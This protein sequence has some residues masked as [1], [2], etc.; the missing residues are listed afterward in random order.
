MSSRFHHS[1]LEIYNAEIAAASIGMWKCWEFA[2]VL[3]LVARK[4]SKSSSGVGRVCECCQVTFFQSLKQKILWH[5]WQMIFLSGSG[6]F[7]NDVSELF[8]ILAKSFFVLNS[9]SIISMKNRNN[10]VTLSMNFSSHESF[11]IFCQRFLSFLPFFRLRF[12]SKKKKQKRLS[13]ISFKSH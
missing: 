9:N 6:W 7:W 1:F 11:K 13:C 10:L 2:F 5:Y 4:Y 3:Q 8:Q 12:F